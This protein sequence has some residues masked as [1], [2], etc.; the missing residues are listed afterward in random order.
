MRSLGFR[1]HVLYALASAAGLIASLGRTWYAPAPAA[2]APDGT[3]GEMPDTISQFFAG[4]SRSVTQQG[5]AAGWQQ[6]DSAASFLL[7]L[8]VILALCALGSLV[9]RLQRGAASGA[10]LAALLALATVALELV[11]QPGGRAATEARLGGWIALASVL[12]GLGASM[13]L[14]SAPRRRR[15]AAKAVAVPAVRRFQPA[16]ASATAPARPVWDE[17]VPPVY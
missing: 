17:S 8:G 11:D 4:L 9:P 7:A 6:L 13:H 1:T 14:C 5:G 12:L 2:P 10:Q 15:P 3:V 16:Q